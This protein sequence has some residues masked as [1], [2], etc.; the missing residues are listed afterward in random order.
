MT[1]DDRTGWAMAGRL[2]DGEPVR[3]VVDTADAAAWTALDVGIRERAQFRPA[4]LPSRA[5]IEGRRIA[6]DQNEG[7]QLHRRGRAPLSE[8]ELALAM[9]HVDGRIREAVIDRVADFPGLLPLIVIRCAD[10]A[11]PVRERA[12]PLLAGALPK[13]GGQEL[14]ALAALVLRVAGRGHGTFGQDLL[15]RTLREA[16]RQHVE[17]L[18]A[19]GD[20]TTRR[21]ALRLAVQEGLL[22]PASLARAAAGDDD[23][24]IQDLCAEAAL[25]AVREGAYDE[26]L[27]PLLGSRQPRVRSA[28]VTALRRA[29][30][31]AQ[32]EP[33]LV[34]RS[35]LVR[36]CARWVLR[37]H[38]IDPLPLY[39]ELCAD[40]SNL[41]LPPAAPLGLAESGT[42]TDAVL[43]VPLLSHP[44]GP[45]RAGA[46]AGL[47]L[48]D[49]ADTELLLPLLDDPSPSV[50]REAAT[51]FL[52][53]A[54]LLP[55][56]W[57]AQRIAAKR[58]VHTRKA[59][60]RLLRAQGGIAQ[61]RAAV[62]LLADE[63]PRLRA[64]AGQT[65]QLWTVPP[66]GVP[67]GDA[68][69]DALLDRC[70]HLFSD[71]VL[72]RLRRQL[73]ITR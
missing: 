32:A 72:R 7:L 14:V 25:A 70:T 45:V 10:W 60:F 68:E 53:F 5:R 59:A 26:V 52:P 12:R 57:L 61:L 43:L 67:L 11:E 18:L 71:H 66:A 48:L 51:A 15:D 1:R 20:R 35:G 34:D 54:D 21:F 4:V 17:A 41:D 47:R 13:V 31:P 2:L 50:A 27:S 8:S 58:P 56:A 40:P 39:R 65:I 28:G 55:E 46:V 3:T 23:V 49:R 37:Q 69:V 16:P 9:C 42:R 64:L 73:G 29:G 36:A 38:G 24:V 22:S 33:F 44:S 19:S 63:S 6:W 62:H 30:R